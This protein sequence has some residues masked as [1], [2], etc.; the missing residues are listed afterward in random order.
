MTEERGNETGSENCIAQALPLDLDNQLNL[1]GLACSRGITEACE[2]RVEQITA[3]T[4]MAQILSFEPLSFRADV[5][6]GLSV[7][8]FAAIGINGMR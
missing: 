1:P 3:H 5:E 7:E 8:T 2:D 6:P 4:L